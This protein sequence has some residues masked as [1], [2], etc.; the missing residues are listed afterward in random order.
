MQYHFVPNLKP[1]QFTSLDNQ[2]FK[3]L[4]GILKKAK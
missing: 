2:W 4:N 1:G 3:N